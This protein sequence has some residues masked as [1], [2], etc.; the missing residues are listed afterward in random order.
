MRESV[1]LRGLAP[2]P[3]SPPVECGRG[4]CRRGLSDLGSCW[5]SARCR[6]GAQRVSGVHLRSNTDLLLVRAEKNRPRP[7]LQVGSTER[8]KSHLL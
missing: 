6:A 7:A 8:P 5:Q 2:V 1:G 4:S 3:P